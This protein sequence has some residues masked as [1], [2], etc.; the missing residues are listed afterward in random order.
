MHDQDVSLSSHTR[1]YHPDYTCRKVFIEHA[2]I[3]VNQTSLGNIISIPIMSSVAGPST[4]SSS[5]SFSCSTVD[6][7]SVGLAARL[8]IEDLENLWSGSKGKR[9]AG[10]FVSDEELALQ[11]CIEE[12]LQLSMHHNNH[13]STSQPMIA[14]SRMMGSTQSDKSH[15]WR[16]VSQTNS[17]KLEKAIKRYALSHSLVQLFNVNSWIAAPLGRVEGPL[18][19]SGVSLGSISTTPPLHQCA[20]KRIIS[21]VRMQT[22]PF[23]IQTHDCAIC[24]NNIQDQ[25]I[26][27]PCGHYYD[28]PCLLE[29]V[30]ASL[31]EE[32]LFP[33]RCCKR[34]IPTAL[35]E[36]HMDSALSS[37]YSAKSF[38]FSTLKRIYCANPTCSR[39]LGPRHKGPSPPIL[40]CLASNCTTQTCSRCRSS[41]PHNVKIEHKCAHEHAQG[42]VLALA[43]TAGWARCPGCE[44][45][46]ELHSGC[47]HM[48][49]KCKTQ[50]CYLCR[51]R[52]RS[53]E[54]PMWDENR[55]FAGVAGADRRFGIVG[56]PQHPV[57]PVPARRTPPILNPGRDQTGVDHRRERDLY[58]RRVLLARQERLDRQEFRNPHIHDT[59]DQI[60]DGND[61]GGSIGDGPRKAEEDF[62]ELHA[63]FGASQGIVEDQDMLKRD[64]ALR[65]LHAQYRRKNGSPR[66]GHKPDTNLGQTLSTVADVAL[67]LLEPA[68]GLRLDSKADTSSLLQSSDTRI[69]RL[70][71]T[72][73][74]F[75]CYHDW[76]ICPEQQSGT[77]DSC[78]HDVAILYVSNISFLNI[79]GGNF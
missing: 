9:R 33:P 14:P 19:S 48:T 75:P 29:L 77:C 78:Y 53:C 41:V 23:S 69:A 36:S 62:A 37:N 74:Q 4:P 54:C 22:S 1:C 15:G 13:S 8:V 34:P 39:F 64:L 24:L 50:F 2:Y 43:R 61:P 72:V 56:L 26:C 79:H 17:A 49:C 38:E 6:H 11:L 65:G 47:F 20:Y 55:L 57:P 44:Q 70:F 16:E 46:I 21:V 3:K 68:A 51:A 25:E 40:A 58:G 31:R 59:G 12:A 28:V 5:H 76:R 45:L 67:P 42:E 66:R 52:W 7:A 18:F 27:V 63:E 32:Y 35:F 73:Q 60:A 10:L 30:Q 71:R